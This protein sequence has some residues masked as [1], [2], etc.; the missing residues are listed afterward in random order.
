MTRCYPEDDTDRE[1]ETEEEVRRKFADGAD[2][3]RNTKHGLADVSD[4]CH[5]TYLELLRCL[6]L[7]SASLVVDKCLCK[8]CVMS[9]DR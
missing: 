7:F 4:Y 6:R 5:C 9:A 8:L 2:E 1:G 3:H